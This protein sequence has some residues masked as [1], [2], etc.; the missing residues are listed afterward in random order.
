[1]NHIYY[2]SDCDTYEIIDNNKFKKLI[3]TWVNLR[4][5]YGH[6]II[7]KVCYKCKSPLAGTMIDIEGTEDW[8][9]YCKEIITMY[10]N[11]KDGGILIDKNKLIKRLNDKINN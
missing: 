8:H 2:C 4:D 11:D 5:G 3:T 7:H 9:W 6:C 1:M 10:Q